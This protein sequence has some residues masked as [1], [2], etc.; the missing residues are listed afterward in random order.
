MW[1][2]I[3]QGCN[4]KYFSVSITDFG[5]CTTGDVRFMN[6]TD[7]LHENSRQ[8]T[9]QICVNNAWGTVCSDNHFDSTDAEVFCGQLE[10]FNRTG[11]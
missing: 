7:I 6:F 2:V 11:K 4:I 5:N 9:L 1:M 10:G 8:G 3:I